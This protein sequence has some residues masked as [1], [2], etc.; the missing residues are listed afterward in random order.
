MDCFKATVLGFVFE[1]NV[2]VRFI[3]QVAHDLFCIDTVAL[4]LKCVLSA[5][6]ITTIVYLNAIWC[7]DIVI[8]TVLQTSDVVDGKLCI[9]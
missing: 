1:P 5:V 3:R 8:I 7:I 6:V 4:R 9:L 2:I